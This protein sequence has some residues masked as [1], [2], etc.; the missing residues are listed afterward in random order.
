MVLTVR[1][2]KRGIPGDWIGNPN[3]PFLLG[4]GQLKRLIFIVGLAILLPTYIFAQTAPDTSAGDASE[5]DVPTAVGAVDESTLVIGEESSVGG[6]GITVS[7]FSFWDLLR[8]VLVLGCVVAV[9]YIIFHFLKKSGSGRLGNNSFIRVLGSQTLP[10][11]RAI[12]LVEVGGQVFMIGAGGDSVNLLAEITD[13]ESIDEMMLRAGD[14]NAG[15][16]KSFGD[17]VSGLLKTGQTGSMDLMRNQRE[18]L[19]R[20]R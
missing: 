4:R 18:R 15:S 1:W 7:P 13:K 2:R 16:R 14:V 5:T 3:R 19:Q 11:N 6:A 8:M 12:Y 9:I 10:G 20:L 17:L